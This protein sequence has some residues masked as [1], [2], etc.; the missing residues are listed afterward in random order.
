MKRLLRIVGATLCGMFLPNTE[1]GSQLL[2]QFPGTDGYVFAIA[3]DAARNRVYIGGNF[4]SVGGVSRANLAA[5]DAAT[6]MVLPW[7]PGT[8]GDV[9]ALA[10]NPS[11]GVLY[12]G[13][14]F[15]RVGGYVRSRAAAV[16]PAGGTLPSWNPSPNLDVRAL[17]YHNGAVFMGGYFTE[18]GGSGAVQR[19]ALVHA[20]TGA[21]EGNFDPNP[22]GAVFSIHAEG[23]RVFAGGTFQNIGGSA[24]ARL[25]VVYSTNGNADLSFVAN[26]NSGSINALALD[27]SVLYM[28]GSSYTQV[29]GMARRYLGAVSK[30]SGTLQGWDPNSVPGTGGS[31]SALVLV[32]SKVYVGGSFTSIFGQ[33][34]SSVAA[35]DTAGAPLPGASAW[36]PHLTGGGGGVF[37]LAVVG[38]SVFIGGD[39]A[40]ADGVV[41]RGF[42][43]FNDSEIGPPLQPVKPRIRAIGKLK[44]K[45]KKAKVALK[46]TTATATLVQS[47]I[48]RKPYRTVP[49]RVDKWKISVRLKPGKT[50]ALVRATGP[51]GLSPVLRYTIRRS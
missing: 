10:M 22:D 11:S 5:I 20:D 46:G 31:V 29:N 12:V 7:N 47:K 37:D 2:T 9:Y 51:G 38:S 34:K 6:G 42:A 19:L 23:T 1:A 4:T 26:A 40:F 24:R 45:T 27:G 25:A 50:K 13:G 17:H 41:R 36:T 21:V 39:F 44:I 48:G 28:G 49:G 33:P 3:V 14:E 16:S 8:D 35:I 30:G 15:G 43:V 32:G 18:I